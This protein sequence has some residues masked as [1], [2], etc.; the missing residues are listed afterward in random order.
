MEPIGLGM[1][2]R[3]ENRQLVLWLRTPPFDGQ[4]PRIDPNQWIWRVAEGF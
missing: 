3:L 2:L 1:G 4:A